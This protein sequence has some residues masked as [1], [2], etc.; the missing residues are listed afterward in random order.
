MKT[1]Q[2]Y[3]VF[4]NLTVIG[5]VSVPEEPPRISL[6]IGLYLISSELLSS[7]NSRLLYF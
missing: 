7:S 6:H 5:P 2:N 4:D 3:T 1:M